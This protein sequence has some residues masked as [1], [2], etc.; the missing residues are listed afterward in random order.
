MKNK[1]EYFISMKR[2]WLD[3]NYLHEYQ[4]N[5]SFFVIYVIMKKNYMPLAGK[6]RVSLNDIYDFYDIDNKYQRN[7]SK[8][9]NEIIQTINQMYKL[10]FFKPFNYHAEDIVD[11]GNVSYTSVI[12]FRLNPLWFSKHKDPVG[13]TLNDYNKISNTKI[14][15]KDNM[16][17]LYLLI[18]NFAVY[19]GNLQRP[20]FKKISDLSM[21]VNLT[22]K[23]TISFIEQLIDI[24]MI[25][26]QKEVGITNYKL[27]TNMYIPTKNNYQQVM[28]NAYQ[29]F[30]KININQTE[31]K[32]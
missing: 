20:Y 13:I 15:H 28:L 4:M 6:S 16:L 27:K 18:Y 21:A 9:V 19:H 24:G 7:K 23:T 8:K 5:K 3:L 25:A 14:K 30:K 12:D 32:N 1:E 22:P 29:Q 17:F 10:E 2:Q 11:F 26:S 31:N